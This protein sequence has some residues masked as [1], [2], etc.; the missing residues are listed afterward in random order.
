MKKIIQKSI[1]FYFNMLAIINPKLTAKKG[2]QLFC[3]PMSSPLKKHQKDFLETGKDRILY[4]ENKKIQTYKW[5]SG[6]K[7]IL[8][9]HGWASHSFRWKS[10]IEQ[11]VANDFTVYAFD[12]PAHGMSD[13][14]TLHVVLYSNII[15]FVMKQT[16]EIE[17]IITHSIGGFAA[18][19]WMFQNQNNP[20]KKIA[21]MAAPGEATD[22][23]NFYQKTLGLTNKTLA[24][25]KN[26]FVKSLEHD[27]SYF[28]ASK[29][30]KDL[31]NQSLIIHDK[32][33]N[34]TPYRNSVLLHNN[35]KNSKLILTEGLGHSLKNKQ[36]QKQ[37]FDFI[38]D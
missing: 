34:E 10:Y 37:I 18:I 7:K 28:S 16:K 21:L 11:F 5:G 9:I 23:F 38:K 31:N 20:I 24:I 30:A 36:L 29:F 12:A 13:G 15:D 4:F 35:W 25:I 6:S 26:E 27:P 1:G 32:L 33:D 14:K 19:Y 8:L 17:Y 22:F 3:S 2:F